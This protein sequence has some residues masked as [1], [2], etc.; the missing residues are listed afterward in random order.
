MVTWSRTLERARFEKEDEFI[1]VFV[2][3]EMPARHLSGNI[4]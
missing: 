4:K 3:L 2:E 1:F